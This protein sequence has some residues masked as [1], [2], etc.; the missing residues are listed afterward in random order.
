MDI[1]FAVFVMMAVLVIGGVGFGLLAHG[2]NSHTPGSR[3]TVKTALLSA[4]GSAVVV[5]AFVVAAAVV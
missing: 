3:P 5:L 1:Q 4:T 2:I